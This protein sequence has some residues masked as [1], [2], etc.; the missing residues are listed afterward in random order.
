MGDRD[1]IQAHVESNRINKVKH[2]V[3][4]CCPHG[5]GI[6]WIDCC[7]VQ[8]DKFLQTVNRI[9]DDSLEGIILF[10]ANLDE[11]VCE[12]PYRWQAGQ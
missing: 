3:V 5:E 7:E 8:L 10:V 11:E 12:T 9:N 2:L 1:D 6:L 4:R